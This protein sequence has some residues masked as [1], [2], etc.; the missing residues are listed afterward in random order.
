MNTTSKGSAYEDNVYE[1]FSSLIENDESA[2][3]T[4][5]R[6]KIFRHRK[7]QC[8]G[9]SREIE[10]DISI[11]IYNPMAKS[12]SWSTLVVVE[13][14]CYNHIVDIADYD[15]FC[16]KLNLISDTAVKGIMVTT[17][18]FSKTT[19]EMA[20]KMH[21]GLIVMSDEKKDWLVS[22]DINIEPECMMDVLC[23]EK[24]L[25]LIPIVYYDGTFSHPI[26]LL[27]AFN[28]VPT[29]YN[30][31]SIP[32]LSKEAIIEVVNKELYMF[33]SRPDDIS[34]EI[35]AKS[36]SDYQISFGEMTNGI[37]A[38]LDPETKI[39]RLS[40]ELIADRK[41]KNFTLAHEIGHLH[42]HIDL[43]K[44]FG[45][46]QEGRSTGYY[47]FLT[48]GMQKRLE[49]QANTFASYLLMPDKWFLPEVCRLFKQYS[50][51]K[52]RLYLDKQPCNRMDTHLVLSA[53]S[54]QFFVSK[55]AVKYRLMNAGLLI[56]DSSY[57]P[58]RIRSLF[59][60]AFS[61]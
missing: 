60:Q 50:I 12:D 21:V 16:K 39:L 27:I 25:G 34:R 20:R 37:Y 38:K 30:F 31:F 45:Q 33:H 22:R 40:N 5:N 19:I 28:V 53:L 9:Y 44:Q 59:Q 43:F 54:D 6:S 26:D 23:G 13:C 11:E 29:T 18:G 46:Y 61:S 2:L 42:L 48:D 56:E 10:T 47:A 32:Q 52:N 4:Q 24:D 36:Y 3:P 57:S 15:E 49:S 8:V 14:K 55:Q 51:T 1:Y 41:R 35:W 58:I 17:K 7:Y